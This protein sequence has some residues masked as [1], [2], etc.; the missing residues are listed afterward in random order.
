MTR[1]FTEEGG[2]LRPKSVRRQS[3]SV[4]KDVMPSISKEL[5]ATINSA[6]NYPNNLI[7]TSMV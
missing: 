5:A 3:V 2:D 7:I 1:K 6:D 4:S